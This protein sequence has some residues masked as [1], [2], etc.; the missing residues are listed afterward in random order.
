MDITNADCIDETYGTYIDDD[1][2]VTHDY[3]SD[4]D[5]DTG[6]DTDDDTDDDTD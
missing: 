1:C 5:D 3:D 2:F 6:N 4:I